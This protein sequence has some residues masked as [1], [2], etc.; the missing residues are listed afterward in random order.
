MIYH[1]RYLYVYIY[2]PVYLYKISDLREECSV[3]VDLGNL[4]KEAVKRRAVEVNKNQHIK[5]LNRRMKISSDS[6]NEIQRQKRG[7]CI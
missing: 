2:I 3:H 6:Q 5:A 7:N 4:A 1:L